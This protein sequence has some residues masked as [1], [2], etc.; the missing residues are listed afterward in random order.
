[1]RTVEK[2]PTLPADLSTA[3]PPDLDAHFADLSARENAIQSRI[4]S[5]VKDAHRAIG[6]RPRY[7]GRERIPMWDTTAD[8]ALAKARELASARASENPDN[9]PD[10]VDLYAARRA[11]ASAEKAVAGYDEALCD[12]YALRKDRAPLDAEWKR[13]GGWSRFFEVDANNGH[14]H[15]SMR[16]QTCNRNGKMTS[17]GWHPEL[18]GL[19]E[20]DA[21]D[22][23]GPMLCTVCF[24]SAPDAWTI[25]K[26]KPAAC[27]N[28]PAKEGTRKIVG[29]KSTHYADCTQCKA[30]G[31]QVN[32]NGR[33]R[34]HK[35]VN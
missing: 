20:K 32:D 24:P 3:T 26:A 11:E 10:L 1:M 16:C 27:E 15:S 33:L 7:V 4:N 6:E 9:F 13:R 28:A 21:V 22:A 5:A 23:L 35:P 8:Q 14:V 18:S 31:I 25:G 29:W 30:E 19:T 12:L 34:R 2:L 17:F